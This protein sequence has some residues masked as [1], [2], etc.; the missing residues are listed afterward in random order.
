MGSSDSRDLLDFSLSMSS[1]LSDEVVFPHAFSRKVQTQVPLPAPSST[2]ALMIGK[3]GGGGSGGGSSSESTGMARVLHSALYMSPTPVFLYDICGEVYSVNPAALTLFGMT[4][5]TMSRELSAYLEEDDIMS[6]YTSPIMSSNSGSHGNY[7]SG[8]PSHFVRR[9]VMGKRGTHLFPMEASIVEIPTHCIE[10]V[11]SNATNNGNNK[12][13]MC[14]LKDLSLEV[15]LLALQKLYNKV[16]DLSTIP[17]VGIESTGIVRLFNDAAEKIFLYSKDQV[18]GKNIKMLMPER[19]ARYHDQYIEN[20]LRTGRKT[21]LDAVRIE[22]G[23]RSNGE[24]FPLELKA[25]EVK[26]TDKK[27]WFVGFV[28]DGSVMMT[29]S[30]QNALSRITNQLFPPAISARI[31]QGE[32]SIYNSFPNASILFADIVGFTALAGKMPADEIVSLLDLTFRAVDDLIL[33][34]YNLLKIKTIGDSYM[35][36]SGFPTEHHDHAKNVVQGALDIIAA[37]NQINK[38]YPHLPAKLQI[39]IGINSGEI[40]AGIVGSTKPQYDCW[41]DTVNLASRMESSGIAG[42]IQITDSTYKLLP[43][44][45]QQVFLIRIGVPVKGKGLLNTFITNIN[46]EVADTRNVT[47]SR[48]LS[49]VTELSSDDFQALNLM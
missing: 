43:V 20:Y 26:I 21:V 31:A 39:R 33:P 25:T 37:V 35:I 36:G 6:M 19:I 15:Q 13:Y 40:I 41:S 4:E 16:V 45:L 12:F 24:L 9:V 2:S 22:E 10:H 32:K 47:I 46:R 18:I 8:H 34:K 28:R 30:E 42:Q 29:Q 11:M 23:L 3:S 5:K 17:V 38:K 44:K 7:N 1:V 14:Y 49:E 27:R 48:R